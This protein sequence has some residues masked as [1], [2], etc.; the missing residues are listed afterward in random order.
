MAAVWSWLPVIAVM[1]M[2]LPTDI[3]IEMLVRQTIMFLLDW[4]MK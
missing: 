4:H 2:S 1:M 3:S